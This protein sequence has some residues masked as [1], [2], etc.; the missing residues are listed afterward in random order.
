[1]TDKSAKAV[2]TA[3]KTDTPETA[4]PAKAKTVR[5]ITYSFT[6]QVGKDEKLPPQARV[7][8]NHLETLG[9]TPRAEYLSALSAANGKGVE[10]QDLKTRQPVERILAFYQADLVGGGY[11]KTAKEE[12]VE[13]PAE[14][15]AA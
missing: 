11:M 1:M 10:G 6:K 8:L 7:L 9:T 2:G 15:K 4:K 5:N 12:K 3:G 13:A 14:K